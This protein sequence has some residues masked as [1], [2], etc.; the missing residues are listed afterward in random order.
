MTTYEEV[1]IVGETK[2][3][4][5]A[6]QT[7]VYGSNTYSNTNIG[8]ATVFAYEAGQDTL[9]TVGTGST[10]NTVVDTGRTEAT[11]DFWK[12][13]TLEFT[14]GSNRGERRKVTGF[15]P[16]TDTLTLDVTT[17][18]LP[19]TPASGDTYLIRGYPVISE[20]SLGTY[21]YGVISTNT[22]TL[23]VNSTN[24]VTATPRTVTVVVTCLYTD[25]TSSAAESAQWRLRVVPA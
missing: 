2:V 18:P 12:G 9:G 10:A 6:L 15:T 8:S 1:V 19:A 11:T 24:G 14:S 3:L 4:K 21:A 13:C 17:D 22:A 20:R 7:K 5:L 25:G 23:E 16:A